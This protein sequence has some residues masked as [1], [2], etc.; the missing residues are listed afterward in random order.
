MGKKGRWFRYLTPGLVFQSVLI[1]GGYGTGA[2]IARYFASQGL[3]GGLLALGAAAAAWAALCAVTFEFA[4]VFRTYDYGS[5][6]R[7]L[8]GQAAFLYDICFYAML[9]LVL[10]VVN[11]TAGAMV[12]ALTGL[13]SWVGVALLS[14]G[15]VL[16]ALKGT[17]AI[18]KA[19]SLWAC[20]LYAV[21]ALFFAAVFHRF[22]GAVTAE[23]AR[24]EIAPGWLFSGLKYASYNLICVS[25]ILYTLRNLASRREAVACGVLAG[26]LGAAPAV[27]LLLAMGCGLPAALA[28]ETPV[29]AIFERLDMPWL[30]VLFE[31]ALFGTLIETAAGFIKALEDRLERALFRTR[32]FELARPLITGAVTA[33]GVCVSTFG[34]TD[35]IDK[36]YGAICY[37][38]LFLFALPMMTIGAAK[39]RCRADR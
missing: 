31:I 18:E 29:T 30:Y 33:L 23:L 37:G 25:M 38:A 19:L 15:V 12:R 28:S 8:L 20:L 1:G 14:G 32:S 13:P 16:L 39:L 6:T 24:A 21:F 35:L 7:R 22:G 34:L 27:P 36:G 26:V 4:R 11:A 10:G 9:L 2:E 5:M 3:L 17:E